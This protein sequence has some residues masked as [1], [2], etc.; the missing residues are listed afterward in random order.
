MNMILRLISWSMLMCLLSSCDV[1]PK[2]IQFGIDQCDECKMTISD[3]RFGGEIVTPKGRVKKFDSVECLIDYVQRNAD[4]QLAHIMVVDYS[5]PKEL[6]N[7]MEAQYLISK[8]IP[9][10]MGGFLSAY[11]SF[12]SK[13][14]GDDEIHNWTSLNKRKEKAK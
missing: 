9:S 2:A 11:S 12:G 13:I 14:E 3:H 1:G 4:E 8:K 6:I 7:A 5:R 10:P